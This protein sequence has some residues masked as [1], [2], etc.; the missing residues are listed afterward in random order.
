MNTSDATSRFLNRP[1]AKKWSPKTRES[2]LWAFNYLRAVELPEDTETLE[3]LLGV[4]ADHLSE[5]SLHDVWRRWRAFYRWAVRRFGVSNPIERID[6]ANGH[7]EFLLEKPDVPDS[8]PRILSNDQVRG[9]LQTGCTTPRDRLMVLVPLD[10]GLRVSEVAQLSK[11]A[12]SPD[13]VRIRGKGNKTR[14]VPI[15]RELCRELEGAGSPDGLWIGK[16]QKPLAPSGVKSAFRRIFHRAGI[17]AGPHSLRHTFAT[18][19]LRRGGAVWALQRI[20]GHSSVS[21]T[22]IY[23]HLLNDDVIRDHRQVSPIREWTAPMN[24]LL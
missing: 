7:V 3:L 18:Q 2:Y 20:L 9:L 6:P 5:S 17:K 4:A 12:L 16:M 11:E 8:L 24:K 23:L 13:G 21:T 10:M 19:Y 14:I 1:A 15:S 22:E